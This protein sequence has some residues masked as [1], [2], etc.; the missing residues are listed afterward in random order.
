M[1]R[2]SLTAWARSKWIMSDAAA[3]ED[4][5]YEGVVK[6]L[7]ILGSHH[8]GYSGKAFQASSGA[9]FSVVGARPFSKVQ[10]LSTSICLCLCIL[11]F[12]WPPASCI[13]RYM[14]W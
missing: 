10:L 11:S 7:E 1:C 4:A 3:K 12:L 9:H 8:V 13:Q 2:Y 14:P 5:V 6:Q